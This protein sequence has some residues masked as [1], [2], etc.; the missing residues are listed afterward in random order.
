MTARC[1]HLVNLY[2][3]LLQ[4]RVFYL[5][6]GGISF[7]CRQAALDHMRS[8][9]AYSSEDIDKMRVGAGV[10]RSR[11][12][13]GEF[14]SGDSSLPPGWLVRV[15]AAGRESFR[16]PKGVFH[17]SRA[18]VLATLEKEGAAESYVELVRASL[19]PGRKRRRKR[20]VAEDEWVNGDPSLPTGWRMRVVECSDGNAVTFL[21]TPQVCCSFH[22]ILKYDFKFLFICFFQGVKLKGRKAGLAHTLQHPELFSKEHVDLMRDGLNILSK[23]N[24]PNMV[25]PLNMMTSGD[26]GLGGRGPQLAARLENQKVQKQD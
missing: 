12:S 5:S 4:V 21:Q 9:G 22:L 14:T 15:G 19:A 3:T 2:L 11:A 16:C 23:V 8:D 18:S 13:Q 1:A 26:G 24:C 20:R 6:P 25:I 7:P 17:P 10:K